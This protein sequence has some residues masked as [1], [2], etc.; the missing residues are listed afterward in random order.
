MKDFNNEHF[1]F[2]KKSLIFVCFKFC[3]NFLDVFAKLLWTRTCLCLMICLIFYLLNFLKEN[4]YI[5][6]VIFIILKHLVIDFLQL[7]TIFVTGNI[8]DYMKFNEENPDFIKG[9]G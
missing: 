9:L 2:L 1:S 3:N 8:Q 5:K 7:L 4:L 6:S